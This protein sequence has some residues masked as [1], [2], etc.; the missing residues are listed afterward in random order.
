MDWKEKRTQL[1][2]KLSLVRVLPVVYYGLRE[3][4]L[5]KLRDN[6]LLHQSRAWQI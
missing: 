5:T 1:V 3:N 2:P 4:R 6:S